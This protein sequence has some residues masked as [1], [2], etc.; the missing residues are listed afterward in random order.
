[1]FHRKGA[2]LVAATALLGF[3]GIAQAAEPQQSIAPVAGL[4]LDAPKYLAENA[5]APADTSLMGMANKAGFGKTLDSYGLT[6]GGWVQGGVTYNARSV[7]V[8]EGRV[9]DFEVQDPTLHQVVVYVN[10][11]VDAKLKTFQVGG[12]MEWMWGGDARLIHANGLFDHYGLNDGP[13]E[14]FDLTQLYVDLYFG[15]IGNGL[16][17]RAGKFVTLLGQETIDPNANLFYSHSYLFGY[18]IPFTHTGAY[19]TYALNDAISIDAGFSRGWEQALEDN[20]G[21]AI[22]LFGRVSWAIDKNSSLKVTFIGGP[23]QAG[24]NDDYRYVLDVIYSTKL[25]DNLSLVINADYGWEENA[26][27]DGGDASW[28]GVAGYL[29]YQINDMMAFNVRAEYFNDNDGARGLGTDTVY[30]VTVGLDIKPLLSNRNFASL[31]FRPEIR[32]D[33]SPDDF[34][35]GG[36]KN[37]QWTAAIDVIFGF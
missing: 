21:C 35:A 4:A 13:D 6:I 26:A 22:D 37:D 33:Y 11:A 1:M 10:K 34:F 16:N 12:R 5:P 3:A 17:I 25:G 7:N 30:E 9:F 20:N 14:Q 19:A 15:N 23:E 36:T 29:S 31:R 27:G 28:C 2:A 18:A 8:S 24:N 32:Y